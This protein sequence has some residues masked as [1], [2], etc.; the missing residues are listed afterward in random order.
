M[1]IAAAGIAR[2]KQLA[3]RAMSDSSFGEVDA[4]IK[5]GFP[6]EFV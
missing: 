6:S 2:I 3:I 4:S 1:S 5:T